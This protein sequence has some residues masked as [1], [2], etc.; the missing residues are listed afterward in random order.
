M[1]TMALLERMVGA[2]VL[3]LAL[4]VF[5]PAL[6]DG[7]RED[8][9]PLQA[10]RANETR[11][12]IVNKAND[13]GPAAPVSAPESAAAKPAQKPKVASAS[14]KKAPDIKPAAGGRKAPSGYA[15]QLGSFG[16]RDNAA[17]YSADV[18]DDGYPVFIIRG[19]SR[20]AEI[21]RVYAGPESSRAKAEKLASRLGS[22][23]YKT[24]VIEL[25]S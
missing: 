4:V 13:P 16:S 19:D 1:V 21:Y 12:L 9:R 8:G 6:L 23:G 25:G 11:V 3:V 14:V 5:A 24:L 18:K 10:D 2:V 17:A 15:V 22:K 7:S 20:G